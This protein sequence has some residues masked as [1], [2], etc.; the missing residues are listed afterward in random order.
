MWLEENIGS[1]ISE[2]RVDQ[3]AKT[4]AQMIATACP[5]CLNMLDDAV[6]TLGLDEELVVKDI[7]ELVVEAL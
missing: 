5:F 3:A 4:T 2:M 1:R 7:M 6:K